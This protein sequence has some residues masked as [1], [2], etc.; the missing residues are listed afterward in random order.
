MDV[1][2]L[3]VQVI[4]GAAGGIAGVALF[5]GYSLGPLGNAVA[6]A[7]GGVLGGGPVAQERSGQTVRRVEAIPDQALERRG[8]VTR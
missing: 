4:S 5:R 7:V 3:L 8:A 6:G 2:S 1:T